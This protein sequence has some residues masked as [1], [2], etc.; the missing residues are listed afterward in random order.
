MTVY[1]GAYRT[2]PENAAV[3]TKDDTAHLDAVSTI[4]VG[5]GGDI[6]VLTANDQVVTFKNVIGGTILPVAVKRVNSTNTD[7]TDMV[8][9]W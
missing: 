2:I 6:A 4:Y 8:A 3:V 5:V 1:G 9:L 7:A